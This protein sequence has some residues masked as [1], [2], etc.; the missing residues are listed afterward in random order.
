M[1]E[2]VRDSINWDASLWRYLR[3]ER[4]IHMLETRT[5][6]F[7]SANEFEDEFEGA[8]AVQMN[9][10]PED[11]RYS[12][13]EWTELAFF[14]LKRLT[15]ISCW[16]VAKYESDAM[17]RLYA[18]KNKGVAICTTPERMRDAF[19]PFRLR[20][21]YGSEDI[22]AG[23]VTY[24]DLTQVRMK[25]AGMMGR[26]FTSTV[27]LNGSTSFDWRSRS[28]WPRSLEC[29]C[30]R[31]VFRSKLILIVFSIGSCLVR[32]PRPRSDS[33]SSDAST[34]QV[35]GI[36]WNDQRSSDIPVT[37]ELVPGRWRSDALD[38]HKFQHWWRIG[39]G[40]PGKSECP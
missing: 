8:V 24:V 25:G 36:D 2:L 4:F 38:N 22:W 31:V 14:A 9:E 12:G 33:R 6:Y 11:P 15:K 17:W 16:H 19:K 27:P 7:A 10:G 1:R 37:F 30:P 35:L 26:F 34:M 23:P 40:S 5:M 32:L 21:D 3:S 28:V 18:E 13:M 29:K 20:P 39:L